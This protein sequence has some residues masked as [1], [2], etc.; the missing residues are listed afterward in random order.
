MLAKFK[1]SNFYLECVRLRDEMKPM[2]WKQ[3]LDHLWTYYNE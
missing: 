2:T 1:K 3:R